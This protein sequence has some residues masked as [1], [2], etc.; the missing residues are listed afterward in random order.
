MPAVSRAAPCAVSRAAFRP[1]SGYA[2][3]TLSLLSLSYAA[4]ACLCMLPAEVR[5][6]GFADV[7]AKAKALAASAFQAP[8]ADL[9]KELRD[10]AYERYRTIRYRPEARQWR[11][12]PFELAFFHP[13]WHFDLPVKI[14]EV[15]GGVRELKFDPQAFDYA[16]VKVDPAQLRKLGPA[17]FQIL[18]PINSA[19]VKDEVLAVLGASY[20]RALGREQR[21][22]ASARGL[23]LDVAAQTGEEFPRFVE[24]WLERPA[25]G[26][27]ELIFYA[28]LDS[29]SAAGAYRFVFT[30][31]VSTSMDV[32]AQLYFRDGVSK[33]AKVGLAPLTSMFFSGENQRQGGDDYRPEVHDSDG[34][35]VHAGNDEWIWRP[36]VNPKRLLVTSFSTTDPR[37]FGLM[38]RDR[39]FGDYQDLEQRFELRPSVWVQPKGKWGAGRIELVQIPAPDETNDNVVAY[40]VRDKAPAS[41][42]PLDL[43]YR[44]LWEKERET[45]PPLAEVQQTRRGRGFPRG[46]DNSI[47]LAIDFDGGPKAEA[48]AEASAKSEGEKLPTAQVWS[49]ANGQILEQAVVPN[50]ATGGWRLHLRLK[51]VDEAKPVELRATLRD[52]ARP[53]SETW[54]YILPPL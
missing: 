18:F 24:F 48:K 23:A 44:L 2:R 12:L 36:L 4:L 10:L 37:G 19:K 22:G 29:K 31:G 7:A 34:L 20:F 11:G 27:R 26:A 38:Q 42:K 49:D 9:P 33:L 43:E 53:V 30:P 54:S 47:G 52:G 40:W 35:S 46:A 6:F 50:A 5:A 45:R 17:G 51:Q 32:K 14:N 25:A 1:V 15:A 16:G 21:Y 28:L 8:S 41:G 39:S 13:G 3:C